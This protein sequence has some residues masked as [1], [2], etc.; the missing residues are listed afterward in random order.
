MQPSSL[1][2]LRREAEANALIT[3]RDLGI[4]SNVAVDVYAAI[5][6]MRLW[7]LFQPLDGLFGMYQRIEDAAGVVVSVKVP[8]SVQRFTAAHELGHH[9][10]GHPLGI[11]PEDHINR[12]SN[13]S[14]TE[15]AAQMFAAEFL[16]PLAAVNAAAKALG[17]RPREINETDTYQLSLRLRSS[18]SAT[19][20]RLQTLKWIDH[21]RAERLRKVVPQT[22]KARLLGRK[23]IDP[24]A[25][26]WLVTDREDHARISPVVGDEIVFSLEEN[27]STGFKW[28][29]ELAAGLSV[30]ADEFVEAN[31]THERE[32]GGPGRRVLRV[33]VTLAESS[34]ARFSLKRTW[35]LS[36]QPAASVAFG[37]EASSRPLPGVDEFQQPALLAV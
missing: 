8:P 18:Y 10:L 7:L 4:A 1:T 34:D 27:P 35:R 26:V 15:L 2:V 31:A 19:I 33:A 5:R 29:A 23:P 14:R 37:L 17:I 16:M 28:D 36:D 9:V 6:Q 25:D 21:I 12:W 32:V 30:G 13:I 22:L 20:T 24:R 3:R 11:D